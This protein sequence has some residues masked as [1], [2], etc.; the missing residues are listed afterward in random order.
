MKPQ[1]DWSKTLRKTIKLLKSESKLTELAKK[2]GTPNRSVLA[3]GSKKKVKPNSWESES[4]INHVLKKPS[5]TEAMGL[6]HKTIHEDGPINF[7]KKRLGQ[8]TY[9]WTGDRRY[10]VWE[11][12]KENWRVYVSNDG[13]TAFEVRSNMSS[14]DSIKAWDAYCDAVGLTNS[15]L[16]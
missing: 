3:V 9:T 2:A 1:I 16:T 11:N 10:W 14:E 5:A 15:K 4:I 13:G 8:Q 12:P 7:H 6:M